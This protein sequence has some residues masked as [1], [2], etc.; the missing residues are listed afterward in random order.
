MKKFTAIYVPIGVSTFCMESAQMQF[1]NSCE[2]LRSLFSDIICPEQMLLD[3]HEMTE[4]LEM[5]EPDLIILQNVTFSNSAYAQEML[6]ITG[7]C[8][9]VLWTLREPVIDGTRL[10]LNSM[11]GAYSTAHTIKG[12]GK[13]IF[14]HIFGSPEEE[15]VKETLKKA[16]SAAKL[17]CEMK[18]LKM[19]IVGH[20]PQG[21][22]FGQAV[23]AEISRTFG[24]TLEY[25]E[26]RQ[27]IE[28][29]L[30][31]KVEE[32]KDYENKAEQV[33][34]GLSKL[35]E[36]NIIDFL[37]LWKAYD[38]YAEEYGIGAIASRCWPD[39][40]TEYGT[41]VCAVMAM[42]NDKGIA[43]SCEGDSYG[44]LSMYIG[45]KLTEQPVFFGD[46]VS[47]NEEDNTFVFWH[48]GTAAYSLARE[49]TGAC[50]GVH[51][52]RKIG[53]TLEFGCRPSEHVTIFRIGRKPDGTFRFFILAGKAVDAPRQFYGTSIV[54]QPETDVR[55]VLAASVLDGWEPHFAVAYGNIQMTLKMLAQIL[56]I[57]VQ[58]Y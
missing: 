29:A 30:S 25:T 37:R 31:Y 57:E 54:V 16:I 11:T 36:K 5:A 27:M 51:C 33:L 10:R 32:L 47:V 49:D 35:P 24:I 26:V 43:T 23:D 12:F 14:F 17:C 58:E 41:P 34:K 6:K 13:D 48:C 56:H 53:P 8:P 9:I 46:P 3:I 15:K 40:F 50:V 52:N 38:T 42:L 55:K 45:Q 7:N 20:T 39:Y 28:K 4:Y 1:E 44:A 2:L 22:G 19:L 18:R 21:F